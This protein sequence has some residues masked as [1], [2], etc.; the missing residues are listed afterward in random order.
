MTKKDLNDLDRDFERFLRADRHQLKRLRRTLRRG[1]R[2][3][4][5]GIC[6]HRIVKAPTIRPRLS[7]AWPLWRALGLL[8]NR[9]QRFWNRQFNGTYSD[10]LDKYTFAW[11]VALAET[12]QRRPRN[13]ALRMLRW[14]LYR[15]TYWYHWNS[16]RCCPWCGY[17]DWSE[18]DD[19]HYE[20]LERGATSTQ[21]GT[22]HWC[23]GWRICPRC[24]RSTWE[25][26]HSL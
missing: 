8:N 25:E 24:G 12:F 9:L 16:H 20:I 23:N 4:S 5:P 2:I 13:R 21:E 1:Q 19:T 26:E 6:G 17:D 22:D 11:P 15:L 10:E 18:H 7:P 3:I 14:P